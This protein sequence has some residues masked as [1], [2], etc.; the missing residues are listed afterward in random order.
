[1]GKR[2]V[3]MRVCGHLFAFAILLACVS[4]LD[5]EEFVEQMD[6]H[7][8]LSNTEFAKTPAALQ[9][10]HPK[11]AARIEDGLVEESVK[12]EDI[13]NFA[14]RKMQTLVGSG[15][16]KSECIK[17]AESTISSILQ[18]F[19]TTQKMIDSL[20]D[21]GKCEKK[22]EQ[23]IK[24][25]ALRWH[26]ATKILETTII[27]K[28][29][30]DKATCKKEATAKVTQKTSLQEYR[31]TKEVVSELRR[32]CKCAVINNVQ[33]LVS[34][35]THLLKVRVKTVVRETVLIC[36]VKAKAKKK[37]TKSCM[38]QG[39]ITRLTEA[40][41]R[42]LTLKT[43]KLAPGVSSAE[44]GPKEKKIK[45]HAVKEKAQKEKKNKEGKAKE[46]RKKE[47][48]T[49]EGGS[50]EGVSKEKKRREIASKVV[51]EREAKE[52]KSKELKRKEGVY[53]EK[54]IKDERNVKEFKQKET[55]IKEQ[56][57]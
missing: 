1:M 5:E 54:L 57:T 23:A 10:A 2:M 7:E 12:A 36:I 19:N 55:T 14:F 4:A 48:K 39:F 11:V 56:R 34:F 8:T 13:Y 9:A 32:Q 46:A 28:N 45:E 44:C 21:G 25:A 40:T 3:A 50:K 16:K 38:N 35:S 15:K 52:I 49:K 26:K 42:K 43:K 6:V 24:R 47:T 33:R 30:T 53:K 20:D 31:H 22:G 51:K 37:S 27:K 41:V 29:E 17:V 18:E